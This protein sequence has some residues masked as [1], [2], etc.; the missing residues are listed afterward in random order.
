[1]SIDL[2]PYLAGLGASIVYVDPDLGNER[3]RGFSDLILIALPNDRHVDV[4]WDDDTD[5][6]VVSSYRDNFGTR[7]RRKELAALD[8]TL[9]TIREFAHDAMSC[10]KQ[11]FPIVVDAA[12]NAATRQPG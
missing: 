2:Q 4:A 12:A 1:M 11:E 5:R 6:F 9:D 3:P 7:I 8:E 10:Q